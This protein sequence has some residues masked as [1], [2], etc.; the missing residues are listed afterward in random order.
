MLSGFL[1]PMIS[2]AERRKNNFLKAKEGVSNLCICYFR[3]TSESTVIFSQYTVVLQH[4]SR[5]WFEGYCYEHHF[6]SCHISG[7]GP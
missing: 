6:A 3:G 4:K 1:K 2:K 5:K 7:D